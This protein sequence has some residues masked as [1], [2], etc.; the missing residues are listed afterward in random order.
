MHSK[1]GD[2]PI[3]Q[4]LFELASRQVNPISPFL[5]VF[6][7]CRQEGELILFKNEPLFTEDKH[8]Q[9]TLHVLEGTAR[10]QICHQEYEVKKGHIVVVP[11]KTQ[12]TF[13]DMEKSFLTFSLASLEPDSEHPKDSSIVVANLFDLYNS[14]E[15]KPFMSTSDANGERHS[16]SKVAEIPV[17][18]PE[19]AEEG[20]ALGHSQ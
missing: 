3:N 19:M 17:F 18:S 2:I 12:V 20:Y 15:S 5:H 16:S 11:S 4:N 6:K 8:F 13:S 10:M 1:E 7:D 9:R 14:T